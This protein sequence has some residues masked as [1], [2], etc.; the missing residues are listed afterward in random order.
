MIK[1][2]GDINTQG[3]DRCDSAPDGQ[4]AE[5]RVPL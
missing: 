4:W 1:E 3:C 5:V 2:Y